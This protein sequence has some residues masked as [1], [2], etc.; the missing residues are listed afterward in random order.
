MLQMMGKMRV[1]VVR[2]RWTSMIPAVMTLGRTRR[3]WERQPMYARRGKGVSRLRVSRGEDEAH[4]LVLSHAEGLSR[5]FHEVDLMT[6]R[7]GE[8]MRGSLQASDSPSRLLLSPTSPPL[9]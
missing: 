5:R 7:R 4:A 3:H 6:L 1:R 8:R 9:S 2:R